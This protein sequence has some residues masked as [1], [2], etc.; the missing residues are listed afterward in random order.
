MKHKTL[1][2]KPIT[3]GF[4]VARWLLLLFVMLNTHWMQAQTPLEY[5]LTWDIN[6]GCQLF[7]PP[8]PVE[9][10]NP[11]LFIDDIQT[12]TCIR[13]CENSIVTYTLT[14]DLSGSQNVQWTVTGGTSGNVSS[15]TTTSSIPVTWGAA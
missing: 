6:V 12:T 9:G 7:S 11:G 2:I 15:N 10:Q 5:K 3:L 1:S 13:V 8:K 14:G 4:K